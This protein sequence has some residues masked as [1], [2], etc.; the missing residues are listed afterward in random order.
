MAKRSDACD[1]RSQALVVRQAPEG[2][3]VAGQ[4]QPPDRGAG[5]GGG[6]VAEA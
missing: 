1:E 4:H 3:G 6:G 2:D 5:G